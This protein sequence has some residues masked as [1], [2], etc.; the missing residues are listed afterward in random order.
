MSRINALVWFSEPAGRWVRALGRCP[1]SGAQVCDRHHGVGQTAGQCGGG[2]ERFSQ[3]KH[4]V[5]AHV[6]DPR[7]QQPARGGLRNQRQVDERR[8]QLCGLC[9]EYQVAMEQHRGADADRVALHGGNERTSGL[10]EI[11]DKP[12]RLRLSGVLAIG[13]GA[14]IGKVISSR[15]AVAVTATS[16]LPR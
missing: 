3:R 10:A 13:L 2:I 4:R 14:E 7:R 5:R 15:K 12:M 6:P 16:G 8:H 1:R 9:Q 11:A